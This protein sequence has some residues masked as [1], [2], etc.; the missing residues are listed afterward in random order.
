MSDIVTFKGKRF[1]R[2]KVK[3]RKKGGF[4]PG[5]QILTPARKRT[6]KRKKKR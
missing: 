3:G 1:R 6:K 4:P 5:T 2:R